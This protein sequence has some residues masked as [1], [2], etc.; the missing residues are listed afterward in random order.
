MDFKQFIEQAKEVKA[1]DKQLRWY[2]W[3]RYSAKQ[4][5]KMKLGG[6]IGQ[7][8]FEGHL[9][10]FLPFLKLGEY[11][12]IGKNTSFGLGQYRMVGEK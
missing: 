6:I 9:E 7:I 2:D 4:D 8:T 3:E 10:P 5:T 12:H 1:V 11:I